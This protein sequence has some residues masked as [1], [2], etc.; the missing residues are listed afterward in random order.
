[1]DHTVERWT[2]RGKL[3]RPLSDRDSA[4]VGFAFSLDGKWIASE[5]KDGTIKIWTADGKLVKTLPGHEGT[6]DD[7]AVD[8]VA[9][10]P[11]GKSVASA[12]EGRSVILWNWQEDL[13]LDGTVA[14][15]CQ[16]IRDYLTNNG[17]VINDRHLCDGVHLHESS[18]AA[19]AASSAQPEA[20][21]G[22]SAKQAM[23]HG[24]T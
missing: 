16:W 1:M 7:I 2:A 15:A 22:P 14:D 23:A 8:R 3:L 11:D 5:S 6:G 19:P 12:S 20:A 10:S 4:V 9:F 24:P 17:E 13:S 18:P 21:S